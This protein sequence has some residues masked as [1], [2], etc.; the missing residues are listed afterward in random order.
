MNLLRTE[1]A[2]I[3]WEVIVRTGLSQDVPTEIDFDSAFKQC[4]EGGLISQDMG[5]L[6]EMMKAVAREDLVG[7]IKNIPPY[8][9]I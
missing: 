3:Q 7:Q 4:V 6:C 9:R 8:S 1:V 5:F 2:A